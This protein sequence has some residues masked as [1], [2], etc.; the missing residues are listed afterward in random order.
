[1]AKLSCCEN[2]P[3]AKNAFK[4][5]GE[6]LKLLNEPNRLKVL[7]FLRHGEQC[8][9]DIR[10]FLDIPQNLTSHHLKVLKDFGLVDSRQEGRKVIY[11]TD[12][13]IMK[14]YTLLL[15][16]FLISNL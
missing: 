3:L 4:Q 11:F 9:C 12:K 10:K 15:N 16:N 2:N 1:M 6:F 5:V 8:V 13:K 14:K 7:C